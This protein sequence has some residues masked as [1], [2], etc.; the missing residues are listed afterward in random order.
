MVERLNMPTLLFVLLCFVSVFLAFV[1]DKTNK[2]LFY[3][4][5]FFIIAFLSGFRNSSVGIDTVNYYNIIENIRVGNEVYVNET[6]FV[7]IIK[8][9]TFI[10]PDPGFSLCLFSFL[11]IGFFY[12]RFWEIR[13]THSLV[14]MCAV[15]VCMYYLRSMNIVRQF[16]AWSVVFWGIRFL[17]KHKYLVF[18][19]LTAVSAFFF[20]LSAVFACAILFIYL[21]KDYKND[22]KARLLFAVALIAAI[23]LSAEAVR[24]LSDRYVSYLS[25]G[26]FEIGFLDIYRVSCI[27]AILLLFS[28]NYAK[29]RIVS[30]NSVG[31]RNPEKHFDGQIKP[32]TPSF[33]KGESDNLLVFYA[34]LYLLGIAMDFISYFGSYIG[35]VS[36][37]FMSYELL[38]WG[39]AFKNAKWK[40][41]LVILG[42]TLFGYMAIQYI[43]GNGFGIFPY[44]FNF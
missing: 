32:N 35:R 9:L 42:I 17:D 2:R 14:F 6:G 44:S 13:K 41:A 38:F 18:L 22:K 4:A 8:V 19:F 15:F 34:V 37:Y 5:S 25:L 40:G 28:S 43:I 23:V 24:F 27:F 10:N 33:R 16:M 20:H 11:T 29:K 31:L 7:L 26:T 1:S 36:L 12:L 21:I 3:F 39:K 30:L